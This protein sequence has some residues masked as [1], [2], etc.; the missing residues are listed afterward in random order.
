MKCLLTEQKNSTKIRGKKRVKNRTTITASRINS[1]SKNGANTQILHINQNAR[2]TAYT[3]TH[4][5]W[6]KWNEHYKSARKRLRQI[7]ALYKATFW[8][9]YWI[10]PEK[11]SSNKHEKSTAGTMKCWNQLLVYMFSPL[12]LL[13]WLLLLLLLL[14]FT[15][16]RLLTEQLKVSLKLDC[17]LLSDAHV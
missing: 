11:K 9:I 13:W 3:H 17:H 4:T 8:T 2:Q 16:S 12:L 14:L 7:V 15:L 6:N 1:Y 10:F 5:I